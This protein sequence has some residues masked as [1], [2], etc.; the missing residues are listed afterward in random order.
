[1]PRLLR[2]RRGF[3]LIELIISMTLLMII[4]AITVQT[5]RLMKTRLCSVF[6]LNED[7]LELVLRACHASG[8]T[9]TAQQ[10]RRS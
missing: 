9:S 8:K 1:M 5:F 7:G 6:L 3:T 10:I 4:T 2:S